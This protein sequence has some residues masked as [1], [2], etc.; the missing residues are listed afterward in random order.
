MSSF[1]GVVKAFTALCALTVA[2]LLVQA[3]L[4]WLAKSL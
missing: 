4:L 3:G 1:L 2:L